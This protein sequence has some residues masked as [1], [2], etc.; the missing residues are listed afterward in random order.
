MQD[1]I[2]DLNNLAGKKIIEVRLAT[3]AEA[4]ALLGMVPSYGEPLIVIVLEGGYYLY[5]E[6]DAEGSGP[7]FLGMGHQTLIDISSGHL[8]KVLARAGITQKE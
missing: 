5:P 6:R 1:Y 4:K 2:D 3:D 7:G 8:D